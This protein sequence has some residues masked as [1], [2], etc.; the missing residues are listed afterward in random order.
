MR[1]I[2]GIS[3]DLGEKRSANGDRT[4]EN[5]V[6]T[7][8]QSAD[9]DP[10]S[11]GFAYFSGTIGFSAAIGDAFG[12]S[13]DLVRYPAQC[14]VGRIRIGAVV[15]HRQQDIFMTADHAGARLG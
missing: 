5:V 7:L 11:T 3:R 12:H 9:V 4:D 15:L 10:V 1:L 2:C 13:G 8:S 6:P 14:F